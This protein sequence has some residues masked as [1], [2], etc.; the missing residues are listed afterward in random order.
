MRK[1]LI[2]AALAASLISSVALAATQTADGSIKTLDIKKHQMTLS[3]GKSF[4]LPAAWKGTGF[5][6]GDKVTVTYE[7]QNGKMMVSA[8]TH[9]S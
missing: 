1:S 4:E 7:A 8:V 3:D 5:K 2:S 9:A 6:V